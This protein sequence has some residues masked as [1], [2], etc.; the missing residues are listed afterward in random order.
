MLSN[1]KI[2]QNFF[3]NSC[4]KCCWNCSK[5]F[6]KK[7]FDL[8][9]ESCHKIQPPTCD[10]FFDLFDQNKNFNIDN[11]KLDKMYQGLQRKVHPDRF[12][13]SS[14]EEKDLSHKVSGCINEAYQILRNPISRG[15]YILQLFDQKINSEVSQDYL[16]DILDLHEEVSNANEVEEQVILLKKIQQ[17]YKNET[18]DLSNYLNVKNN[19]LNDPKKA[20]ESIS[21][22]KYLSRIRDTLK[23]KMPVEKL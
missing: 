20:G 18:N 16:M 9:C 15:E 13:R 4:P 6:L 5:P 23:Q 12:F 11:D 22:L 1:N 14:N 7:K 19:K 8:F 10:N 3:S 17:I 2:I 21:K